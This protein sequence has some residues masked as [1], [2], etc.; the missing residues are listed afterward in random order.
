MD[1]LRL[2]EVVWNDGAACLTRAQAHMAATPLDPDRE[3]RYPLKVQRRKREKTVP[4]FV[5]DLPVLISNQ[6]ERHAVTMKVWETLPDT[7][8][9]RCRKYGSNAG[10]YYYQIIHLEPFPNPAI[11][12]LKTRLK[13]KRVEYSEEAFLKTFRAEGDPLRVMVQFTRITTLPRN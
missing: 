7:H 4:R 10:Y 11:E 12:A 3:C 8:R 1:N 5:A 13:A 6:T 9:E 2:K